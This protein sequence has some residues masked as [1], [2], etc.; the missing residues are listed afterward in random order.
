MTGKPWT[1]DEMTRAVQRGPHVS[2]TT[3]E[4]LAHFEQEIREKLQLGQAKTILWDDIKY[5]PPTQL[6]ISP[7]AAIPHKSNHI[8]QSSTCPSHCH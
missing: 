1:I 8:D 7:I 6:K 2:A 5:N 4:A 3:P